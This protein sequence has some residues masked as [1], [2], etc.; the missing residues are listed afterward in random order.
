MELSQLRMV[1]AVAECGS[2]ARAAR[3]LHCVPSNITTRIKQLESELGTALFTRSGRGLRI[4]AAG[5]VF[6]GYTEQILTLVEQAKRAVQPQAVPT[7]TLRIGAIESCATGRLPSLLATFHQRYPHVQLE[8]VTGQW[9]QLLDDVLHHRLDGAVVAVDV[10][11]P[12]LSTTALYHE[13]LVIIA[14]AQ[15]A[16]L[17][18]LHDVP[19]HT[20]FMWPRGCPYRAALENWLDTHQL[21]TH[22]ITYAN[23]G[24]IIG[25]VSAGAGIAL[26]PQGMLEHLGSSAQVTRY[27]F[28]A[29][30][31]VLN[32]FVWHSESGS[33]GAR[34]AFA[35]LLTEQLGVVAPAE[36]N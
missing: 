33:H 25:C 12:K 7:G 28:N 32:R 11:Q 27:G 2:I 1:K 14:G 13:E 34:D 16:P 23:W 35:A 24:S 21:D 9:A 19:Q 30:T 15:A 5:L 20:V 4:S 29:L 10:D 3:Q 6:I 8:L 22:K 18:S 31:P 26:V 36:F 17:T